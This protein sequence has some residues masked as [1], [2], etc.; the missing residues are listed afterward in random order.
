LFPGPGSHSRPAQP[1]AG[2][3]FKHPGQTT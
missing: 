3:R 2:K 1:L